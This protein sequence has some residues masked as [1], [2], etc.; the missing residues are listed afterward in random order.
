MEGKWHAALRVVERATK[1]LTPVALI[2]LVAVGVLDPDSPLIEQLLG[3]GGGF[4]VPVVVVGV[5]WCKITVAVIDKRCPP[6]IPDELIALIDKLCVDQ[7]R[8]TSDGG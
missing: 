3:A 4:T 5:L 6:T 2:A 8:R 1:V 7:E